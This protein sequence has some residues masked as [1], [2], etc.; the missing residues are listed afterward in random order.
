MIKIVYQSLLVAFLLVVL[1]LVGV[2]KM[3]IYLHNR[4]ADCYNSGRYDE[5]VKYFKQSLRLNPKSVV[6]HFN[7]GNA[8]MEIKRENEAVAEYKIAIE[9]DPY[10]ADAY[11]ALSS[12][13]AD[14][15]LFDEAIATL[16]KVRSI[17]PSDKSSDN[18]FNQIVLEYAH[19]CLDKGIESHL[20][21]NKVEAYRLVNKAIELQPKFF[22][23]YYILAAF[24]YSQGDYALA[25]KELNTAVGL[26]DEFWPAHKLLGDIYFTS[27]QFALA[28]GQY[29]KVVAANDKDANLYHNLGLALM[30]L[31]RYSEALP[32]LR[33][34]V[35]ITGQDADMQYSLASVYRDSG[36]P[37]EAIRE[38]E[39]L[40]ALR[41]DYPNVH[42]DLGDIYHNLRRDTD[43]DSEFNK[44]I[45][46][47]KAKLAGNPK[48]AIT[49]NDYAYALNGVGESDKAREIIEKVIALN[50]G[51][52]QAQLTLAKIYEKT[53][54]QD[55]AIW[56]LK[57]ARTLSTQGQFI[58]KNIES[59]GGFQKKSFVPT[60]TVYL[61]NGRQV[62]GRIKEESED[63]VILEVKFGS[64][65]GDLIFYRDKIERISKN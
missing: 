60:H 12:F 54:R 56:A 29:M 5:A 13:Y 14:R 35:E 65:S 41:S 20:A 44:E 43:A 59:I 64:S 8:Y 2:P 19:S 24:N 51:Y 11:R 7:L 37:Q 49:L 53:G 61:R 17:S 15:A 25:Q 57:K 1:W 21:G 16:K 62:E 9:M 31:E 33:K 30:N 40:L 28:H 36:R 47:C 27:G 6:T 38:Y 39:K 45:A 46:N 23:S 3:A 52:R 34:A 55:L 63:K 22:Y 42:N 32:Y 4:G 58:D 50:P 10:A 48:D 18:L 26:N